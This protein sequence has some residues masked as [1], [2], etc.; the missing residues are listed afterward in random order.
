MNKSVQRKKRV[1][2][3][4]SGGVDSSVC[5]GILKE[6]GY[7]V[8]GMTFKLWSGLDNKP[9]ERACCSIDSVEDARRVSQILDIPHYVVN[10]KKYFE[11]TVIAD[12][13]SEYSQGRTPN[14][15]VRCNEFIKF[16]SFLKKA[17]ALEADY[18]ATGHYARI[19][20]NGH[21]ELLRAH[22]PSKD[23]S[24]VLYVM[25]QHQL[26]HSL[27]PLG[28]LN[29][30]DTREKARQLGLP[31]AD[32][33][34]SQE[35]CFV[36]DGKYSN[37][38]SRYGINTKNSGPI[39][40]SDGESLGTHKGIVNYTIGQRKGLQLLNAGTERLYVTSINP[41]NSSITVG[42][43]EQLSISSARVSRVNWIQDPTPKEPVR[44]LVQTRYRGDEAVATITSLGQNEATILFDKP[45]C[46][47]APGQA[48]VF[49]NGDNVLGGGTIQNTT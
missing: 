44:A 45:Q 35:I 38:L 15:C 5:A 11:K 26:E 1:L 17:K 23:Q 28:N 4:M 8:I 31:V 14:P 30:A 48:A 22:D 6:Q 3:A 29:K 36:G 27:F 43:K 24:Y 2:V 25:N 39:L 9:F 21:Y 19:S 12:F 18:V 49:Y 47:V 34:D 40:N 37:F 16:D 32:K 7:E 42:T 10:Y 41:E 13:V 20:K 46:A 33:K